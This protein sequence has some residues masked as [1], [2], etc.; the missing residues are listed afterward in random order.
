MATLC[1]RVEIWRLLF[2]FAATER[3]IS[4]SEYCRWS[5]F[6]SWCARVSVME[7]TVRYFSKVKA[8]NS[9][10]AGFVGSK[11]FQLSSVDRRIFTVL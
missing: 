3:F 2:V 6:I 8:L 11:D 5:I 7:R 4:S 10:L 1:F 9:G